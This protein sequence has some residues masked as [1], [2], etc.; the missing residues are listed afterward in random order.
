VFISYL[1][2]FFVAALL[3]FFYLGYVASDLFVQIRD[4]IRKEAKT[5]I[6]ETL[7]STVSTGN[8][9]VYDYVTDIPEPNPQVGVSE[10]TVD[11]PVIDDGIPLRKNYLSDYFLRPP[12]KL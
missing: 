5:E 3:S 10:L 11:I 1:S 7:P 6:T 2:S 4:E 9:F 8:S 12:P